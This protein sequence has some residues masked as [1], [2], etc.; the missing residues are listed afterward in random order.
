LGGDEEKH[1]SLRPLRE[2]LLAANRRYLAFISTIE[3][4]KAGTEKLNKIPQPVEEK[5]RSYRGFNFFD[6]DNEELFEA[7]GRGEFS[8]S[9]FQNKDLRRRMK[10]KNTGQVSRLMKRLRTHGLVKKIGRTY[11]YYLTSLGKQV[12]ALGLKLKNLYV[13]SGRCP[14]KVLPDS[15]K[16]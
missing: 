7:L 3:D 14:L 6:P 2:L 8:I 13:F 1:Y 15:A 10:G 5:D 9:G 12:T 4:D 11:K 16:I